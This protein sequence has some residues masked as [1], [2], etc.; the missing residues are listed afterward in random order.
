MLFTVCIFWFRA[1]ISQYNVWL[2]TGRPGDLCSIPGRGERVFPL[3]SVSRP[4]LGPTQPPVQWVPGV[5]S[6]GLKRGRGVTLTTHPHL[7]PRS[8][9]RRSY[10]SSPPSASV[11]CSGTDLA[12]AII[13]IN[14]SGFPK[15]L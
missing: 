3:T 2:R 9:M 11:A 4:A 14:R 8:K 10:T 7:V 13:R 5:L 1:I 12:S 15:Q 6:P